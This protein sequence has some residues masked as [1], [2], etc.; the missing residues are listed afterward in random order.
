MSKFTQDGITFDIEDNFL[1]GE[2]RHIVKGKITSGFNDYS[3]YERDDASKLINAVDIDWNNAY[4]GHNNV[5]N[6]TGDLLSYIKTKFDSIDE[7]TDTDE[8]LVKISQLIR[9]NTINMDIEDNKLI[10]DYID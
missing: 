4:L 2:N 9:S 7:T 1:P 10:V 6:S 3:Q 8:L 5:I